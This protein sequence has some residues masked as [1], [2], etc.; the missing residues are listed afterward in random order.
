MNNAL[1]QYI[2]ISNLYQLY[3]FICKVFLF[4]E[5]DLYSRFINQILDSLIKY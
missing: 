2:A 5:L 1:M 4:Q 3:N